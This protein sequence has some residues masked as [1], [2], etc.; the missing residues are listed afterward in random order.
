MKK[1][2]I[3]GLILSLAMLFA[4]CNPGSSML[5]I[6]NDEV[7]ST[8]QTLSMPS[9]EVND[10]VRP[11]ARTFSF[12]TML[13]VRLYID[14]DFYSDLFELL[15]EDASGVVVLLKNSDDVTV[16]SGVTGVNGVLDQEIRVPAAPE[17]MKLVLHAEGY[18]SRSVDIPDMVGYA[19]VN[20]SMGM[21]SES[22]G[23]KS[24]S[25]LSDS[26]GDGIPDV[27]DAYPDDPDSAFSYL[28][29]AEGY[30]TVAYE[31]LF[32]RAQAG[33]ADYNDFL[34]HY[35]IEE[36]SGAEGITGISVKAEAAVK[37]AGYNH[38]FGI[39]IN[40]FVPPAD[41]TVNYIDKNGMPA[42][43]TERI[44]DYPNPGETS[45]EVVLFENTAEAVGKNADFTLSFVFDD[46]DDNPQDP[47]VLSRPP[48]NPYL[49][50]KNTG[51]DVH[52][53][54]EEPV[55]GSVNP[56]DTFRDA[57]GFPWGLLVPPGSDGWVHPAE[58]QRIEEPYPRF[59]RWRE[60]GGE[61][62]PDWYLYNDPWVEE[63][64]VYAAGYYSNGSRTVAAYWDDG[65]RID[66]TDGSTNA[67]ATDIDVYSGDA[68][69]TGYYNNGSKDTAAYWINGVKQADLP[70][71]GYSS[72]ANSIFID[73]G[74]VY[75]AG[76]Y[77]DGVN[78]I[79]CRWKNGNLQ[80]ALADSTGNSEA[81]S[82]TVVNGNVYISG[83]YNN[84]IYPYVATYW[85]N[86]IKI[87]EDLY[88]EKSRALDIFVTP[89]EDVYVSGF[90]FNPAVPTL[91]SCYWAGGANGFTS[92]YGSNLSYAYAVSVD[93]DRVYAAGYYKD[94]ADIAC[95]WED[96]SRIDLDNGRGNDLK[97]SNGI[98][99][100]SGYYFDGSKKIAALWKDGLRTDLYDS[101]L[102]GIHAEALSVD[103]TQ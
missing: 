81:T 27:Y 35:S 68:Y 54:D 85:V 26:D 8:E 11:T 89:S 24:V 60:S 67:Q 72:R 21:V 59:T 95:Y 10:L 2:S 97:I 14:V 61:L 90:Y 87:S 48:Y 1:Y 58:G 36:S 16:F 78:N 73:S 45:L 6:Y 22:T 88:N 96:G 56:D 53:I 91:G 66:L 34:S 18:K 84:G 55:Y 82:V 101:G 39:R 100:V 17:K 103:V 12:E 30:L 70:D 99:Y 92:L 44:D 5:D 28:M 13:P 43:Y 93:A 37:L 29:P 15:T 31:D 32:G 51:Y 47:E 74:D 57:D 64:A 98:K 50:I 33:D 38:T 80:G 23:S 77:N 9:D 71:S 75:I 86:G 41:L 4:G 63:P 7:I 83:Y 49:Y 40:S 79:A 19:E 52:L 76:Y 42:S 94:A 65:E 25:G 46:M 20:R 3:L 69:V 62:S 102:S